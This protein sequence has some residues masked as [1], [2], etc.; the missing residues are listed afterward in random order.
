MKPRCT[1]EQIKEIERQL[2]AID[3]KKFWAEVDAKV[4]PQIEAYR[5]ARAR[6]YARSRDRVIMIA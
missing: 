4:A 1:P 2:N 5:L 6:S 3:W